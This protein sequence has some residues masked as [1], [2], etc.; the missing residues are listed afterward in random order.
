MIGSKKAF[1][2]HPAKGI[3]ALTAMIVIFLTST[4][5]S[6]TF[7]LD[8]SGQLRPIDSNDKFTMAAADIKR[9]GQEGK[10]KE[11]KKALENLKTQF[12]QIGGADYDAFVKA[13][14]LFGAGKFEKAY[15]E[16]EK[17]LNKFPQSRFYEAALDRQFAIGMAYLQGRKKKV[18]GI[19]RISGFDE[20]VK[21]MEK[22]ADRAGDSM[23]AVNTLVAIADSY[24]KRQSFEEAYQEWSLI[25]DR[26]PGG[27][28][29]KDSL[30]G[31]ARCQHAS[32]RGP[33]FDS[34]PLLSAKGYYSR[35]KLMYPEDA[36]R[37]N[38]DQRLKLIDEQIAYKKFTIGK[39]YERI[40]SKKSE[41]GQIQ[42]AILYFDMVI[43]NWPESEAAKMA[44]A[45]EEKMREGK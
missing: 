31:M 8:S 42:P 33:K 45:E 35:F 2:S 14:L 25:S 37:L 18:L 3:A 43:A 41:A 30:L 10:S 17:F 36:K 9:L 32:Y 26:W 16:Y 38:I 12:P 19:F 29:A 27:T 7:R 39:Y 24:E 23:I 11:F 40:E 1:F 34:S 4:G 15:V 22:V 5:N 28:I 44:K 13:E 20:G 21:V 6:G